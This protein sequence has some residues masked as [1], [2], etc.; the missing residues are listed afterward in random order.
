MVNKSN[1]SNLV[2]N[3]ELNIKPAT[4]ATKEEL[5]LEQEKMWSIFLLVKV[6]EICLFNILELKLDKGTEYLIC[7]KGLFESKF[8]P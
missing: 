3:S 2:K 4:L 7:W 1:I 5:K 8:F 6:F